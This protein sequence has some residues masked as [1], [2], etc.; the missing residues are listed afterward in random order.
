MQV[1]ETAYHA[2]DPSKIRNSVEHRELALDAAKAGVILLKNE[3]S[4]IS[5]EE[6]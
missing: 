1:N 4:A 5:R 3:N 2:L 6:C